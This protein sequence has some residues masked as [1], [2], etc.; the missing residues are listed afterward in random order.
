MQIIKIFKSTMLC[1][2]KFLTLLKTSYLVDV[3]DIFGR[4]Y[5]TA[6]LHEDRALWQYE[7]AVTS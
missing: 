7:K 2:M 4:S 1:Y 5:Y 6:V 3:S